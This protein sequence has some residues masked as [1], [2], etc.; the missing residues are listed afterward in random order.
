MDVNWARIYG[1]KRGAAS[2]AASIQS[3][4]DYWYE[5]DMKYAPH[6]PSDNKRDFRVVPVKVTITP[7][8]E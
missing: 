7:I 3:N 2:A 4:Y 5:G 6:T 8:E 1:N